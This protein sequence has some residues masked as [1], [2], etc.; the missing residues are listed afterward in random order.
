MT[1]KTI[2]VLM[3]ENDREDTL[4]MKDILQNTR[5]NFKLSSCTSL[6]D[7]KKALSKHEFDVILVDLNLPDSQGFATIQALQ[8]IAYDIP[9]IA[10]SVLDDP[11][12]TAKILQVGAQDYLPKQLLPAN[13]IERIIV[14][15]LERHN[16][17]KTIEMSEKLT[18]KIL[19][20]ISDGVLL[21]NEKNEILFQNKAAENLLNKGL[22]ASDG[23]SFEMAGDKTEIK[24]LVLKDPAGAPFYVQVRKTLLQWRGSTAFLYTI[25]DLTERK[26]FEEELKR[27]ESILRVISQSARQLLRSRSWDRYIDL[28]LRQ[29]GNV[30]RVDRVCL[31]QN[32]R[33]EKG[34]LYARVKNKWIAPEKEAQL[35]NQNVEN[36][37]LKEAGLER[38]IEEL[39]KGRLIYGDIE[40]F[41]VSEKKMLQELEIKS[42]LITPIFVA[43]QWWGFLCFDSCH[44]AR[45]WAFSERE[46]LLLAADIL[47][48][49][50]QRE[51]NEKKMLEN[52]SK[53]Q[54]FIDVATFGILLIKN[55]HI[56]FANSTMISI[57]KMTSEAEMVGKTI[58]EVVHPDDLPE[59]E[60][61]I[62][63]LYK[64]ANKSHEFEF[65]MIRPNNTVAIVEGLASFIEEEKDTFLIF[66]KDISD[67]KKTELEL[68]KTYKI[69]NRLLEANTTVLFSGPLTERFSPNHIS[70]NIKGLMGFEAQEI[71]ENPQIYFDGLHPEDRAKVLKAMEQF[72]KTGRFSVEYRFKHKN[73]HYIWIYDE[74]AVVKEENTEPEM[75]GFWLDI[76]LK[77]R[78]EQQYTRAQRLE[79]LGTLAGGIAHDLNNVLT[80]ILMGTELLKHMVKDE[81]AIKSLELME[82]SAQRGASLIKQVL[83]FARGTEGERTIVQV[84]YLIS[85]AVK[86]VEQTFPKHI[87][88]S[89]DVADDLWPIMADASQIHQVLMNMLVN[90]RDAMPNGGSLQITAEN[91]MLDEQYALSL[92]NAP[93]GPY[94]MITLSDTGT[95]IAA[96]TIDKIFDPFFTTKEIGKGT[97]MGLATAHRIIDEHGGFIN[98]YSEAN[99]GT[100]FKIYLPAQNAVREE[101]PVKEDDVPMGEGQC[102]LL[103]EDEVSVREITKKTLENNGYTVF[104]AADGPEGIAVFA[105]NLDTINLIITDMSMPLMDGPSV[106]RALKRI[107][108][109]IKII[110][111]S[112]RDDEISSLKL[113]NVPFIQKPFTASTLLKGVHQALTEK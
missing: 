59:V 63:K 35:Q 89:I 31:F 86:M 56:I 20:E 22:L 39:S 113:I 50:V 43:N 94:V 92:G 68:K 57:M 100:S 108:E 41:P 87:Q 25:A 55:E 73:G 76:S 19:E 75:N 6:K 7:A 36:I 105:D 52:A 83:A 80:P 95:G 49:A 4:F 42:M 110:A 82:A 93:K 111:I 66:I 21:I 33:D 72:R 101:A 109:T 97:G 1:P 37:P 18:N 14:H 64:T 107:N 29:L 81:R 13:F 10:I 3:I 12:L 71:I 84:R 2:R 102:I 85:E 51:R 103:I 98:V 78:Y 67:R 8:E 70:Q 96:D 24:E 46:A 91:L 34:R 99:K 48:A 23:W 15:A 45:H 62:E 69:L 38:W 47:G 17:Y 32:Y 88:L 5:M 30:A 112:G 54:R 65:R 61:N 44:E 53:F 40:N 11:E 28:I 26:L 60:K 58:K 27:K 90:A 104:T 9:K 74:R 106:V 79:S 77:K 16:L